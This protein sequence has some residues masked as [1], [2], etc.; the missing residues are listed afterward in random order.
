VIGRTNKFADAAIFK[1]LRDQSGA[2]DELNK[3]CELSHVGWLRVTRA[4]RFNFTCT[5]YG[6]ETVL[7]PQRVSRKTG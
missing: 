1:I 3:V 6:N 4:G 5:R 7:C 2:A